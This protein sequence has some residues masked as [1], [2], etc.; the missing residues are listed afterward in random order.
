VLDIS[1]TCAPR[2]DRL[3]ADDLVG[4]PKTIKVTGVRLT[5]DEAQPVAVDF[6][7]DGGRPFTPGKSMRR[8]L[9]SLWGANAEAYVGRSM[10]L[11]CDP[12]IAYAGSAVGGVRIAAMSDIPKDSSVILTVKRAVRKPF[13]VKKLVVHANVKID[14]VLKLVTEAKSEEELKPAAALAS[15]LSTEDR[16][17]ARAAFAEARVK[18]TSV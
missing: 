11:Y 2:S 15:G 18:F 12:S 6:E 10:V 7:G 5:G 9:V 16:V 14:D 8:V 13:Q 17:T 3:N 1:T 4:G